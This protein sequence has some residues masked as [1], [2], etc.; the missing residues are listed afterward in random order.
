MSIYMSNKYTNDY[1]RQQAIEL[2]QEIKRAHDYFDNKH[3]PSLG[4]VGEELLRLFLRKMFQNEGLSVAQGFVKKGEKLSNQCDIIIYDSR[5]DTIKYNIG[6]LVVVSPNAV[7]TIIEVKSS[8]QTNTWKTTIESYKSLNELG[9]SKFC[10]FVYNKL[11]IRTLRTFLY[12]KSSSDEI[13]I[14]KSKYDHGDENYL[15]NCICS[16]GSNATYSLSYIDNG[17]DCFGYLSAKAYDST[18]QLVASLHEFIC[19]IWSLVCSRDES[20]IF[21][22]CDY[23]ERVERVV[24]YEM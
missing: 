15:P 23:F 6:D 3:L 4:Y 19:N 9:I 5:L 13:L 11:S 7:K 16:I 22:Q 10:I 20:I 24:L 1:F 17:R 18:N 12:G 2:S 21:P 8:I 14:D